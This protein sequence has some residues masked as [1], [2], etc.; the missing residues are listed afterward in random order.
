[1]TEQ[2]TRI[3]QQKRSMEKKNKI[4]NAGIELFSNKGYHNTNST[5]IANRAEVSIGTFYAY[6]KDKKEV[7]EECLT[8]H[9]NE[10][11]NRVYSFANEAI[12]TIKDKRKFFR[13]IFEKFYEIHKNVTQRDAEIMAMKQIDPEVKK[14]VEK[15]ETDAV[16]KTIV[17]LNYFKDDLKVRDIKVAGRIINIAVESVIHY[18]DFS[19]EKIPKEKFFDELED[20][21]YK[22]LFIS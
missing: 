9:F 6:F 5:D 11:V 8:F 1:M 17:L 4:I 10:L 7:F 15:K 3:P 20:M 21:V 2:Q 18:I 16:E 22:Y 19:D 14:L 13:A 12:K